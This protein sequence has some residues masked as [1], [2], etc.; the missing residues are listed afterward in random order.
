M[1]N[2]GRREPFVPEPMSEGFL[3]NHH[4]KFVLYLMCILLLT[5]V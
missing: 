4:K 2:L 5:S 1:L 3:V